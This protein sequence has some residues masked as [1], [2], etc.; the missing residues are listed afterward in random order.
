[1]VKTRP[2][3]VHD[4]MKLFLIVL[5]SLALPLC[6]TGQVVVTT[7]PPKVTASKAVVKIVIKNTFTETVDSARAACFLLDEQGKVL[8][9]TTRW[10]I[11]GSPGQPALAAGETNTFHFVIQTDRLVVSTNLT[12][13]I[14]VSR[15]VLEGGKLADPTKSVT[16]QPAGK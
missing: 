2:R 4:S 15:V 5:K 16:I 14:N 8:G 6:L 13:R 10:I 7:S 1:M 11:G 12:A 3:E 9:Q